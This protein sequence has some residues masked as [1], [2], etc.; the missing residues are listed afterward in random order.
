MF[1]EDKKVCSD[2]SY[3][4]GECACTLSNSEVSDIAT[5]CGDIELTEEAEE[6]EIFG[7]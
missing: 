1:E 6:E 7:Y 4:D 5:A 2:C 3:F